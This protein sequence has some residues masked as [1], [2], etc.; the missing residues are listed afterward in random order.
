MNIP[1]AKKKFAEIQKL[2]RNKKPTTEEKLFLVQCVTE[3]MH[4]H[5][6]EMIYIFNSSRYVYRLSAKKGILHSSEQNLK[7]MHQ[8]FLKMLKHILDRKESYESLYL[9][10]F[11]NFSR[12]HNDIDSFIKVM[13]KVINADTEQKKT[14][15]FSRKSGLMSIIALFYND[16]LKIIRPLFSFYMNIPD[17]T[18]KLA[19]QRLFPKLEKYQQNIR[20]FRLSDIFNSILLFAKIIWPGAPMGGNILNFQEQFQ[21]CSISIN[22][23]SSSIP[24]RE[25]QL[26]GDFLLELMKTLINF[27]YDGF[28]KMWG[29]DHVD[30][31]TI[32]LKIIRI[33]KKKEQEIHLARIFATKKKLREEEKKKVRT[34]ILSPA[35]LT[36]L[37][38]RMQQLTGTE[39][40]PLASPIPPVI[41]API[42][43]HKQQQQQEEQQEEL[44][45]D[46][47]FRDMFN[48][49]YPAVTA[50]QGAQTQFAHFQRKRKIYA[51][52]T[53][54]LINEL[55]CQDIWKDLMHDSSNNIYFCDMAN[56]LMTCPGLVPSTANTFKDRQRFILN[57]YQEIPGILENYYRDRANGSR[58]QISAQTT[59]TFI[60]FGQKNMTDAS[61]SRVD[62][63][64]PAPNFIIILVGCY[65]AERGINC[66]QD[67]EI[68]NEMDDYALLYTVSQIVRYRDNLLFSIEEKKEQMNHSFAV[69]GKSD[70][71]LRNLAMLEKYAKEKRKQRYFIVTNDKYKR[72]RL[73][74]TLPTS[75]VRFY[76]IPSRAG[77]P[78]EMDGELREI[79]KE[80]LSKE[81]SSSLPLSE[82]LPIPCYALIARLISNEKIR[83]EVLEIIDALS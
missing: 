42:T 19:K 38:S 49:K 14:S 76:E 29:I 55:S 21:L 78:P 12:Y 48:T 22:E 68:K 32:V 60:L 36:R 81:D 59:N 50:R 73:L 1:L 11:K 54:A 69:L 62:I 34:R 25:L 75:D 24:P 3:F 52:N 70:A 37:L 20:D 53:T 13:E 23:L 27:D 5:L 63:L 2:L 46:T 77:T 4:D 16:F 58:V 67:K 41:S 8:S 61:E 6:G 51:A 28:H 15:I 72:K 82:P 43:L 10:F 17:Q 74:Y 26:V 30:I 71:Y 79:L 56:I 39:E 47:F 83:K 57:K 9:P 40:S 45:I 35:Q 80:N 31:L 64:R 7:L 44:N 66:F 65:D 18:K 33:M